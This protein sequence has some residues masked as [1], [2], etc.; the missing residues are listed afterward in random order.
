MGGGG[1]N[2]YA[3]VDVGRLLSCGLRVL[4]P[5][6]AFTVGREGDENYEGKPESKGDGGSEFVSSDE[7]GEKRGQP[8]PRRGT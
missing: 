4:G 8:R 5:A 1:S 7:L 6:S 2:G 3:S